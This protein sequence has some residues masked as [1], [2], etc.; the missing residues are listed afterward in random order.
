MNRWLAG[1]GLR[2]AVAAVSVPA[3]ILAAVLLATA[4]TL[5]GATA[6][7]H[8][9]WSALSKAA[10]SKAAHSATRTLPT[11]PPA[12][13]IV[14]IPGLRWTDVSPRAAPRLWRLA[15][16]GS[17]GTLVVRTVLP[18]TCPV[19]GWLTLNAG[20]RAMARH[21]EKGMCPAIAAPSALPLIARYN[22]RF[23]Y[24]PHWGL[25]A[26]GAGRGRC[27]TAVG[28]GAALALATP[29]GQP[30][31]APHYLPDAAGVS[32]SVLA[33]CPLTVADLGAIP[34][35]RG[36]AAAVRA[37]DRV[38][39]RIAAAMPR[40]GLLVVAA[41]ADGAAPHLR[42]LVVSGPGYRAGLLGTTSTRQP[43]LIQLTDLT[44]AVLTWRHQRLPADLVGSPLRRLAR[45]GGL[46][47]AVSELIGQD[48]AA[49]VHRSTAGWFFAA[50]AVGDGVLFGA[51]TLVCWG[52]SGRKRRH[53]GMRIAGA[54][55]GAV[56]PAS[57]LASLAPWWLLP[58]QAGM[59]YLLTG[60]WA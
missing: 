53:R 11:G 60:A 56:V 28:P 21:T 54:F 3:S 13:V 15:A 42:V 14:G 32:R 58:H 10:L 9:A 46:A 37:D 30:S 18:R 2:A 12:V 7:T 8:G 4:F 45:G 29:P 57:F 35:A 40:G 52:T 27:A 25:L 51:I 26:S 22:Q 19:D 55:T 39:G 33:R 6:R 24:N 36:R 38:L 31:L 49:Q 59:L 48:T 17:V 34:V 50:Y 41:P 44:A 43:G 23:H 20:A 1:T 5:P 16:D 47:A